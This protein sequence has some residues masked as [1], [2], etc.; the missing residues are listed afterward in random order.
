MNNNYVLT[1]SWIAKSSVF[2]TQKLK[3]SLN[4]QQ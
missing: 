2:A 3:L 4:I 1:Y